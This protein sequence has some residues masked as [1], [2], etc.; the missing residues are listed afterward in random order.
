MN[1][2]DLFRRK[3]PEQSLFELRNIAVIGAL[4]FRTHTDEKN[5]QL[6]A[7]AGAE[8]LYFILHIIDVAMHQGLQPN[9]RA[10]YF[11]FL[12]IDAIRNYANAILTADALEELQASV[13]ETMLRRFNSRQ[14]TYSRCTSIAGE[15]LPSPGSKMFALSFFV[16]RALGRTDRVRFDDILA[17]TE[18]IKESEFSDFPGVE[19]TLLWSAFAAGIIKAIKLPSAIRSLR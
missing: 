18:K 11:N 19:N 3:T 16:H 9:K 1:L 15:I 17:G 8:L 7:N 13:K 12:T 2:L 6:S 4:S 14:L 5:N 10:D